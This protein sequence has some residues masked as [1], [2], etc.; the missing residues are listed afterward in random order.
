M[1]DTNSQDCFV[2]NEI[3]QAEVSDFLIVLIAYQEEASLSLQMIR[4]FKNQATTLSMSLAFKDQLN[5]KRGLL[6]LDLIEVFVPHH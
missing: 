3:L 2:M 5:L 4:M 6:S 1:S